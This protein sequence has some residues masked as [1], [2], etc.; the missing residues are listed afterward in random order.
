VLSPV[1]KSHHGSGEDSERA[2]ELGDALHHLLEALDYGTRNDWRTGLATALAA[3]RL[4][5]DATLRPA[6]DEALDRFTQSAVAAQLSQAQRRF[7]ELDFTL[8]WP[9]TATGLSDLITGQIDLIYGDDATG[10]H[11]RDFKTGNYVRDL[12]DAEILAPY[13]FQLGVYALAVEQWLGQPLRSL[14]LI[15]V[16]PTVR[17]V[18]WTWD[19]VAR[20]IIK[21]RLSSALA[22][23]L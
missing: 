23:A 22:S 10:W 7:A 16:R 6:I 15:L 21:S 20:E 2:G 14:G 3:E 5:S 12:S 13:T 9:R 8:P 19:D 18:L 11:V 17:E 4:A 1:A